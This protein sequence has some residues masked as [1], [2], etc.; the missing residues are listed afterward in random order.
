MGRGVSF[1]GLTCALLILRAP[2]ARAA[3][4]DEA[5][6]RG[7]HAFESLD[8]EQATVLLRGLLARHPHAGLAA[9]AKL[10]L[11]FIALNRGDVEETRADFL[12]AL[13]LDP[14][15]LVPFGSAPKVRQLFDEAQR[16]VA[17]QE[18]RAPSPSRAATAVASPPAPRPSGPPP[19]APGLLQPSPEAPSHVPAYLVG[20]LGLAALA[21]GTILG[22][23][24]NGTLA[25]AQASREVGPSQALASASGTQGLTADVLFGAGA[26]GVAL[27]GLLYLTERPVDVALLP[28]PGGVGL[29]WSS[30]Y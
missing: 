4:D 16:E 20:G 13:Q 28:I 6:S 12:E 27:G 10:Y 30:R 22:L 17:D 24:A 3:A 1:F 9:K 19:A 7:I 21:G 11:G 8:D 18:S 15:L 25:Q 26:V 2:I 5:L 14:T 23:I 29:A